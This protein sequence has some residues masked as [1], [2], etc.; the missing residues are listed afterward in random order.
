MLTQEKPVDE[1]TSTKVGAWAASRELHNYA[2]K[3][4][5][6]PTLFVRRLESKGPI[7]YSNP[8]PVVVVSPCGTLFCLNYAGLL[9]DFLGSLEASVVYQ[10]N[11]HWPHSSCSIF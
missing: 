8:R 4:G 9:E 2:K 3:K 10:I 1:L 7:M 6:S 11:R 5:L